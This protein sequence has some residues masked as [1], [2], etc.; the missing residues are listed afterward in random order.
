MRA[1]GGDGQVE[2]F[3]VRQP[4]L[5]VR[6]ACLRCAWRISQEY[7][8]P[9]TPRGKRNLRKICGTL[10]TTISYLCLTAT[11]PGKFPRYI[12]CQTGNFLRNTQSYSFLH[13]T[14][15]EKSSSECQS[16]SH[17]RY[18][19]YRKCECSHYI[20]PN[21]RNPDKFRSHRKAVSNLRTACNRLYSRT[22][23][24]M[25]QS[26][27]LITRTNSHKPDR[28][29]LEWKCMWLAGKCRLPMCTMTGK[30]MRR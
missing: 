7:A 10:S 15:T 14:G 23:A 28:C 16:T 6:I 1:K 3:E 4:P 11:H 8:D 19:T 9:F 13:S 29:S 17:L 20:S 30:P 24:C 21:L 2:D 27:L 18:R 25:S 12:R 26:F 22:L 5:Q